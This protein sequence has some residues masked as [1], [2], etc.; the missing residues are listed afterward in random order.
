MVNLQSEIFNL[1]F[2]VGWCNPG[3]TLR[4]ER[5]NEGSNPSPTAKIFT[6]ENRAEP[7]AA[8]TSVKPGASA[9]GNVIENKLNPRRGR[10]RNR[11]NESLVV[12][13]P[14]CFQKENEFISE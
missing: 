9:P 2:V 4:S 6:T 11:S 13:D 5:S 7:R 1:Q 14:V 12:L 10:Q 3:N 8:G